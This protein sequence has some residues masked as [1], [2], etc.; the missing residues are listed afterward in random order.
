M[1]LDMMTE[2]IPETEPIPIMQSGSEIANTEQLISVPGG[3][4]VPAQ[5]QRFIETAR[6][7]LSQHKVGLAVGCL[8]LSAVAI[9]APQASE[10]IESVASSAWAAPLLVASEAAWNVGAATMLVATGRKIGNPLKLHGRVKEVLTDVQHSSAFKTGLA[11]NIVGELG[12][13]SL[14]VGVSITELPPSSWPLTIGSAALLMAP[15]VALWSGIYR[16]NKAER[17]LGEK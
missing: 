1:S 8:A 6:G 2:N 9:A 14:I 7:W 15:G 17:E 4:V 5:K 11:V 13:A 10:T 3:Y 16:A 12:T